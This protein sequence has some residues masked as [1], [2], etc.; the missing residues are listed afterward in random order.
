MLFEKGARLPPLNAILGEERRP[1][2]SERRKYEPTAT[3]SRKTSD[4]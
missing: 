2:S 3:E 1:D 4:L